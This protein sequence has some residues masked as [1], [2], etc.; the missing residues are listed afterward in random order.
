MDLVII[1]AGGF[2]RE[3][4]DI[5]DAVN[6]ATPSFDL[7][8]FVDDGAPDAE[9]LRR[10]GTAHIGTSAEL[11]RWRG[12]G[13]VV[14][15]SDPAA[16]RRLDQAAARAGLEAVSLV[17]PTTALGIDLQL[18]PGSVTAAHTSLTTNIRS[19][20]HLHVD[21]HVTVGHDCRLGDY[22]T[23]HPGATLSGDVTLGDGVRVGSNAVVIQGISVGEGS[24][25]GA[26]AVVTR[27]VPAGQTV[28]GVPARPLPA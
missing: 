3:V 25:V 15:V 21:R 26:G 24:T 16:R 17:H 20:R 18:G 6:R 9:V 23:L 12:A 10:R 19:G 14:A 7:L 8:G 22:V 5:V 11:E 13:Y 1:G 27:P 2:G 28:V 4:G